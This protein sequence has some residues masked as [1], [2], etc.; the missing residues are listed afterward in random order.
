MR[1]MALA[2]ERQHRVHHVLEHLGPGQRCRPWSRG[3]RGPSGCSAPWPRTGTAS[4]PR[5][6]GRR[7]PA[8]TGTCSTTPSA[9]SPRRPAP[10]SAA[11]LPRGCARGRSRPADTAAPRRGPADRRGSSPGARTPRPRRTARARRRGRSAPPPAAAAWT[12][13][14]RVRRRA[15]PAS[16][17]RRRRRA[18]DRT[19]R[20][21][22]TGAT[23]FASRRRR[24][25]SRADDAPSWRSAWPARPAARPRAPRPAC[26][27]RR[28]RRSAPS[29][30]APAR[31]TP[32]RRT[33]PSA[34]SFEHPLHA[35]AQP[36]HDLPRDR[37]DHRGHLARVNLLP[38]SRRPAG[39]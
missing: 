22:S 37:A 16:P 19:R 13:R 10:A 3:R 7:C 5:A 21:R 9:P 34:P 26:S 29:T 17:A 2:L 23:A 30:S 4:P 11:P 33:P 15:A 35:R 39:R 28:T 6:P 24:T 1:V 18:R 38:P 14:C 20:C 32:G 36:A 31:R 8:P 12:C 25:A 27:S